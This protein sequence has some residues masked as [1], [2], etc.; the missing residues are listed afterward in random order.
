MLAILDTAELERITKR[1]RY[2]AQ[3]RIL[4]ALGVPFTMHPDGPPVVSRA[5]LEAALGAPLKAVDKP[6]EIFEVDT[7]A[8]EA[9]G[10]SSRKR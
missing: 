3:A 8:I 2:S 4:R 10:T 6:D 5:A 9:H 7:A 1:R